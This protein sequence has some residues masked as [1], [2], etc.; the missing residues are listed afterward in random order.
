MVC[1]PLALH[2]LSWFCMARTSNRNPLILTPE[3]RQT[4]QEVARSRTHPVRAV[5]R[6]H[7]LLAYAERTPIADIAR[8]AHTTRATVYKCLDK[9]LAMGWEA[10]L[11]DLYH[12]PQAPVIT[13]E[14][15][16]W[17]VALACT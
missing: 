17:V 6:A 13:P 11:Q 3:Q 9:A 4:L 1:Y 15:K 10:G 8:L 14:A 16:A 5:Q 7:M 2:V 12:R